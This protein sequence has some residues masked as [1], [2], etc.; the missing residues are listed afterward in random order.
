[1][2]MITK[3]VVLAMLGM[4]TLTRMSMAQVAV[5]ENPGFT[6]EQA[7][8]MEAMVR[9]S[10][11]YDVLYPK[12]LTAPAQTR[13]TVRIDG[14]SKGRRW[15][16]VGSAPSN[17]MG[18]MLQFYPEEIQNDILDFFFKPNFGM[19][20]THLKV[21]VGGDNNSTSGTE[22][23][24]AHTREEFAKPDF[25]RG[26]LYALMRAARDR[27]PGIELGA[28]AWTQPY[29][30]GDGTGRSDNKNF[31]TQESADYFVKFY[32]GARTVWGLDMQY[33]SPEQNER[34]PGG[35]NEWV[36]N[37]L[38]PTFDRAGLQDVKF[39]LDHDG[40][41]LR[42]EDDDPKLLKH[43]AAFGRHYVE[44]DPRKITTKEAQASGVPLWNAE[45]WSRIGQ[46]WPLA[47][48]FAESVAR[49][50]V[51]S[52]I[53]QFTTWPLQAG[54]LAG[55]MYNTTGLMMANKPWSG[56]YEIYPTVWIT[57]HFN[58]FAPMGWETVDGGCGGLFVEANSVYDRATIGQAGIKEDWVRARLNYLTL[59]SPDRKDY[60]II[61]VNTSPFARTLD[62][63]LCDL[64]DKPLHHWVTTESAQFE[65][66]ATVRPSGGKFTLGLAPWSICSLTTTTG[67]QKGQPK[68][69]IPQDK[70]L[71]L[72]YQDDFESYRI[73]ADARYTH[74][75][76]GY[77]E[78]AQVTGET[79]TLRQAVP[80]KGLTWAIP[81]DNYPCVVI[82]DVRWNDYEVS[83]DARLEGKGWIAL[84]ARVARFRDHGLAGYYLRVDQEGKWEIGVAQN[85][86]GPNNFYTEKA[87]ATGQLKD[88][89]AEAWH[90][91]TLLA[92]G[93]RLKG[94]IDGITL[95]EV[96][97]SLFSAGAVGYSTWA[98]GIQ[99]DFEDMKSAMVIGQ[100]YGQARYDNL[101]V[102][103]VPGKLSQVGW[104][105]TATTQ[106]AGNEAAKAIDGDPG[107]FWHSEYNSKGPLPQALTVDLGKCN[108]VRE[109]RVLQRQDGG[110]SYITK[111]QI[112]FSKDGTFFERSAE[113]EWPDEPAMK[114][115]T[116]KPTDTR[117]VRIE[118]LEATAKRK[119]NV[120]IAEI[121]IIE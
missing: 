33:F 10:K 86:H 113:G 17:A 18:R 62:I 111:F 1:M 71:A 64:P 121:Q 60:S 67:Q 40:W 68:R 47:I 96:R 50:Y 23:T 35:R 81:K 72:P 98:E 44:N 78:V 75:I 53:T 114:T 59:R 31:F 7:M 91:L 28:L 39:I 94:S 41:P 22:P 51:D 102:R 82:G 92:D 109:V 119:S 55:C 87:L 6:P 2:I 69:P 103:A 25:K 11:A 70:V 83:S 42:K 118:A 36:V 100:K 48:Y 34:H 84:W 29:W 5:P 57:A 76:A 77:F 49:C 99:R 79:K 26:Y 45:G 61:A 110:H 74:S 93:D 30:V 16:G 19:A 66:V 89:N 54:G 106:H 12:G 27:N 97:D 32:E 95:A 38:R 13:A 56:Y 24:F 63:E 14:K 20:L 46:N 105:A 90:K 21:E 120:S 117:Y 43:I 104:T 8:D 4:F 52:K 107:T 101:L 88:F 85:R 115:V 80:A 9:N 73:G 65:K 112:S 108:K 3:H 15:G 116:C 37:C 58:Q